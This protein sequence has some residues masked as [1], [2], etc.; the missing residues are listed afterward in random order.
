MFKV[1]CNE[2]LALTPE[3]R[4]YILYLSTNPD[5]SQLKDKLVDK[6]DK[7]RS[8]VILS[9]YRDGFKRITEI[10]EI[11]IKVQN[12]KMNI[13]IDT[14]STLIGKIHILE[15]EIYENSVGDGRKTDSMIA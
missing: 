11:C 5:N 13:D 4:N 15:K 6:V 10:E 3:I 8:H 9:D 1:D 2:A 14:A 12:E 7:L